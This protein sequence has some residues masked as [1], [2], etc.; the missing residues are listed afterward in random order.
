ML[1]DIIEVAASIVRMPDGRVLMAE[2]TAGQISPG[3]W[4]LPGGKIDS[5]ESA[6][7]AA[8]REL[9]EEIGI[10]ALR[11]RPWISYV[12]AF[13]LRRIR[14]HF[15]KVERWEGTPHGREGQR[16]AWIDPAMPSVAPILPSVE[17]VLAALG[18]PAF[19]AVCRTADHADYNDLLE[20]VASGVR[21][22][23]RLFQLRISNCS[24]DQRVALARRLNAVVASA[25]ARVLLVGSALEARRAGL[26]G[27]HS[28]AEELQRLC[29][30]PPVAL[31]L[32]SCHD[33][34]DLARAIELGAD[35]AVVSPVSNSAAHPGRAALGWEGLKRLCAKATLPLYAQGGLE[36][37]HLDAA[38]S[39]GAIGIA[40]AQWHSGFEAP[41]REAA[42]A[43]K[44]AGPSRAAGS[45]P[46]Q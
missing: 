42:P 30:R 37:A 17:R 40:T 43:V 29:S 2:R 45:R 6:E 4:E 20:H 15:F 16:L 21:H 11:V 10:R 34:G 22:G 38:R 44:V 46:M 41:E 7:H 32:C 28:T 26:A 35:G 8:I 1:S 24:P 36:A 13:P 18:L 12:H 33:E 23:L 5:G 14:L 25:G 39:A 31:W 27:V 9:D 19:Y 3:F